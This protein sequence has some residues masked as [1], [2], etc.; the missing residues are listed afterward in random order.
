MSAPPLPG[1]PAVAAE[2]PP[3]D[4]SRGPASKVPDFFQ[5]TKPRITLLV[6]LTTLVGFLEGRTGATDVVLMVHTLIGTGLVAA[7]AS[8]L[9]QWAERRPDAAMRRTARRPLPGGRLRP[10]EALAFGLVLLVVGAAYLAR[11]ANPLASLLAIVTAASYLLAYTPLKKVTPLA[12]VI[13]AVPGAIPPLIGWAAVRGSLDPGGWALFLI[14]FLWQMP[15]FLAIAVLFR[16]D[17]AQAG[18][19]VLPVVEPDLTST[20]RQC[21]LYAL[22][23]VPVSL[24]PAATG[25]AGPVYAVGALVLSLAYAG[26]ALALLLAPT[27]LGRARRLFRLSLAYLPALL[28]LLVAA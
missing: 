12:T 22:A 7:A 20:G 14:V 24:M 21:L 9:N 17:Y 6:V 23:L 26:A 5:L 2:P 3:R 27:D 19:R 4:A 28:I 10:G 1:A 16:K 25:L 15:H 18:F 13:G 11:L 8:A